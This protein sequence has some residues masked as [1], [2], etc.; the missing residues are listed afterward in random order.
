MIHTQQLER[1]QLGEMLDWYKTHF[2]EVHTVHCQK[3]KALLCI[4]CHGGHTIGGQRDERGLL[5]IPVG[6]R[7]LSHRVRLDQHDSGRM[8]GYECI[9]GNDTRLSA[10]EAKHPPANGW[11]HELYPHE[12][13]LIREKILQS[14]HKPKYTER[15]N[16]KYYDGK[17]KVT[18]IH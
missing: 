7:M 6:D 13:H 16:A 14:G 11:H 12:P 8:I 3:C 15:G 18:R 5:V 10:V 17:F 2:D 4:E 9:C 1:E